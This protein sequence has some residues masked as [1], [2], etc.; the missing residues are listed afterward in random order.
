MVHFPTLLDFMT[1][2]TK[3]YGRGTHMPQ[4]AGSMW[5]VQVCDGCCFSRIL[6]IWPKGVPEK[7]IRER[8]LMAH[9]SSPMCCSIRYYPHSSFSF[10]SLLSLPS[11]FFFYIPSF[12]P[13]IFIFVFFSLPTF[14]SSRLSENWDTT[15]IRDWTCLIKD[16]T[17]IRV[18]A[19]FVFN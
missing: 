13:F 3:K 15:T 1:F 8:R 12:S 17:T 9:M 7:I 5:R 19:C 10:I 2:P 6:T 4:C 11:V 14:W 18:C 16:T